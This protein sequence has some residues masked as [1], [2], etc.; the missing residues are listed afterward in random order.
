MITNLAKER[1]LGGQALSVRSVVI[2]FNPF[3]NKVNVIVIVAMSPICICA[4][5]FVSVAF[6]SIPVSSC[7]NCAKFNSYLFYVLSSCLSH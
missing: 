4:Q 5:V 2:T 3:I 7:E 1:E 6:L